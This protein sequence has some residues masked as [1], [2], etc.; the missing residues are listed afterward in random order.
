MP[1]TPCIARILDE[2]IELEGYRLDPGVS[3]NT[4]IFE[5][6]LGKYFIHNCSPLQPFVDSRIIAYMVSWTERQ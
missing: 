4:C 6:T 3:N 2:P 5:N 1:T